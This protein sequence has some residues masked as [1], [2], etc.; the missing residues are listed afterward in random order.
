[1]K[2]II[3]HLHKQNNTTTTTKM[4]TSS[5]YHTIEAYNKAFVHFGQV[6]FQSEVE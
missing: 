2:F 6:I 4:G 1:M 3:N 5:R